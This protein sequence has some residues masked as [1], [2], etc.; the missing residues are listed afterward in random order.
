MEE[1]KNCEKRLLRVGPYVEKMS[2]S[3]HPLHIKIKI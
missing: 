1:D 2:L 3:H